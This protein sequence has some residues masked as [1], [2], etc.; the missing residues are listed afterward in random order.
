MPESWTIRHFSQSNGEGDREDD[1]PALLRRVASSVEEY[2]DITVQDLT[3]Q[4]DITADG[5]RSSMTVYFH[6]YE[7]A[8]VRP[9][10]SV[11]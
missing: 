3:F 10:R 6:P 11:E 1:V 5:P 4:T 8:E 2:G 7:E 9:L